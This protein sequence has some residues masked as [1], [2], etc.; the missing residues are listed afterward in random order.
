MMADYQRETPSSSSRRSRGADSNERDSLRQDARR[1]SSS[2]RRDSPNGKPRRKDTGFRWKENRRDD[3]DQQGRVPGLQRGY[4]DHY[5]PRLRSRSP[6]PRSPRRE[7]RQGDTKR[8]PEEK[9]ERNEKKKERKP[10]AA[11]Q[12]EM[13]VVTVNDRLGT[14]KAIP[15]FASDSVREYNFYRA[16]SFAIAD[17]SQETSKLSLPP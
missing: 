1:R 5:R 13:I 6:R 11:T 3:D 16:A 9:P 10:A 17:P 7:E 4:R 14:K 15:C 2:P 8:Q 12:Q